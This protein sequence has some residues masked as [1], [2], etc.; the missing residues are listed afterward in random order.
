MNEVF[1]ITVHWSAGRKGEL[2]VE[3]LVG[4]DQKNPG[5]VG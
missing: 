5:L 4:W 1:N 3:P 2:I